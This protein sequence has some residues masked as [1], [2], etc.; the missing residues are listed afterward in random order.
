MNMTQNL[1]LT[2][3]QKVF[4]ITEL[5][6][7]IKEIINKTTEIVEQFDEDG[8]CYDDDFYVGSVVDLELDLNCIIVETI[9][10]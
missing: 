1:N 9:L 6:S 8:E 5:Q 10:N 2:D 3:N 7:K 4:L